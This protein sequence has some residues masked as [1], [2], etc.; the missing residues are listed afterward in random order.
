MSKSVRG[1]YFLIISPAYSMILYFLLIFV[2]S[3][4]HLG[5][6]IY[7]FNCYDGGII[8]FIFTKRP[9]LTELSANNTTI[10]SHPNPYSSCYIILLRKRKS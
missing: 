7:I 6:Y 3:L 2:P 8:S 9:Q 10:P 1:I 5:S 4:M